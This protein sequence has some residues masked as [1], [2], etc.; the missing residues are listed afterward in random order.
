MEPSALCLSTP[1]V[2]V[3]IID[4]RRSSVIEREEDEIKRREVL[5][6]VF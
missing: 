4:R 5:L 2:D 1:H 6:L 3:G